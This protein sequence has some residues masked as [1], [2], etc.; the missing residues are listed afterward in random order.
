MTMPARMCRSG[1]N[2]CAAE[3]RVASTTRMCM[4]G[5][6]MLSVGFSSDTSVPGT[7]HCGEVSEGIWQRNM[8]EIGGKRHTMQELGGGRG[9]GQ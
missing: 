2:E 8:A 3:W 7:D 6:W 1:I 4:K 9:L 5:P